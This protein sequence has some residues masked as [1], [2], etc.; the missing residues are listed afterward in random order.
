MLICLISSEYYTIPP[1][2]LCFCI[3]FQHSLISIS[4]PALNNQI[5]NKPSLFLIDSYMFLPNLPA[6]MP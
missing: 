6:N 3:I 1:F 5:T 2:S 4:K